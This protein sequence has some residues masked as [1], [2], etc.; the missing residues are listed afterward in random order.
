MRA[1]VTVKAS[2]VQNKKRKGNKKPQ[3]DTQDTQKL[4]HEKH[5]LR[6]LSS[7]LEPDA[8]SAKGEKFLH[9][10]LQNKSVRGN[11]NK[12]KIN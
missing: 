5:T 11:S 7:L 1:L 10:I 2:T 9:Q 6:S 8:L 4:Q 12:G 3:K